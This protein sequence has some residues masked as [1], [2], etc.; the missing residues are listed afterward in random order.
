MS[1]AAKWQAGSEETGVKVASV[2]QLHKEKKKQRRQRQDPHCHALEPPAEGSKAQKNKSW[3]K[4]LISWKKSETVNLRH[5]IRKH[6]S[7]ARTEA[8][9]WVVKNDYHEIN[10]DLNL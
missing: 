9:H 7:R 3:K 2:G 8:A 6:T 5:P 10:S 1:A 4:T